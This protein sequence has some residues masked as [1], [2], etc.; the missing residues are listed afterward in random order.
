[1][2]DR[3]SQTMDP[4]DDDFDR[5][6]HPDPEAGQNR[7]GEAEGASEETPTAY[8]L[9]DLHD[10]LKDFTNDELKQIPILPEGMRLKQGAVYIDLH[11]PHPQEFTARGDQEAIP[12]TRIVPKSEVDYQL[13][14]RLIGVDNPER[15]GDADE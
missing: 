9:K 6:L 5:D 4:K 3:K 13:W 1:M 15:T 8:D 12:G 2:S 7:G 11:L 14:N 10:A